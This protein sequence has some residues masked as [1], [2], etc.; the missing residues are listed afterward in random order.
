MS[1]FVKRFTRVG[2][3]PNLLGCYRACIRAG[4][5]KRFTGISDP[6]LPKLHKNLAI[7]PVTLHIFTKSDRRMLLGEVY[8]DAQLNEKSVDSIEQKLKSRFSKGFNVTVGVNASELHDLNTL[9]DKKIAHIKKLNNTEVSLKVDTSGIDRLNAKLKETFSLLTS[10]E[11]K[12]KS[13]GV[14]G[15]LASA[16]TSSSSNNS[17]ERLLSSLIAI[18][19]INSPKP[20]LESLLRVA[21]D[22]RDFQRAQATSNKTIAPSS[23]AR[24]QDGKVTED[25]LLSALQRRD[26]EQN[27]RAETQRFQQSVLE[28]F[29]DVKTGVFEGIGNVFGKSLGKGMKSA[30]ESLFKVDLQKT[31]KDF[32]NFAK[33][34]HQQGMIPNALA[35]KGTGSTQGLQSS[36]MASSFRSSVQVASTATSTASLL[37]QQQRDLQTTIR[38]STQIISGLGQS[39]GD[40]RVAKE[41]FDDIKNAFKKAY[42]SFQESLKKNNLELAKSYAD[43]L[44]Q[45]SAVAA[46]DIDRTKNELKRQ[47]VSG[48]FGSELATMA[49]S[50]KG[51]I[52]SRYVKPSQRDIGLAE[53]LD[54]AT[55]ANIGVAK[56]VL[57]GITKGLTEGKGA[58]Y[59]SSSQVAEIMLKAMRDKL[60]IKSPATAFIDMMRFV[61]Q[62]IVRGISNTKNAVANAASSLGSSV[63]DPFREKVSKAGHYISGSAFSQRR[64]FVTAAREQ[65]SEQFFDRQYARLFNAVSGAVAKGLGQPRSEAKGTTG[66]MVGALYA[67]S[68]LRN[69][70]TTT[71]STFLAPFLTTIAPTA[72]AIGQMKDSILT[73]LWNT[74]TKFIE[75]TQP[76]LVAIKTV[77]GGTDAGAQK[78]LNYLGDTSTKFGTPIQASGQAFVSLTAASEGTRLEGEGI[79]RL[80]EGISAS[81]RAMGLGLADNSLIFQA[82]TQ[83]LA[84]GKISMEELRQQ[85][86]EKFPPAMSV[87]A[88]ALGVTTG[89]L[90]QL[91]ASGV[92]LA[93]EVLPKVAD[94]LLKRYGQAASGVKNFTVA[95]NE[96]NNAAFTSQ[97]NIG[98]HFDGMFSGIAGI[99]TGLLETFNDNFKGI[100]KFLTVG[101]IGLAAQVAVGFETMFGLP[102]VKSKVTMFQNLMMSTFKN[103]MTVLTPFIFSILVD[104]AGDVLGAQNTVMENMVKG[105]TNMIVSVI[106]AFDNA[107][108]NFSGDSLFEINFDDKKPKGFFEG[109]LSSIGKIFGKIP[110]ITVE[111]AALYIMLESLFLLIKLGSPMTAN[112]INALKGVGASLLSAARNAK[113]W[114]GML[115]VI[116]ADSALASGAMVLLGIATKLALTTLVLAFA[117]SDFTNPLNDGISKAKKNIVGNIGEIKKALADL[118]GIADTTGKALQDSLSKTLPSKGLQLN[119]LKLLGDTRSFTSDD[120]SEKFNEKKGIFKFL[121]EVVTNSIVRAEA[122]KMAQK[123]KQRAD[124]VGVGEYFNADDRF[125]TLAK[126][127]LL[128]N[129]EDLAKLRTQLTKELAAIGQAVASPEVQKV[130]KELETYDEKL[131]ELSKERIR[132]AKLMGSN[133]DPATLSES[134]KMSRSRSDARIKE[135]DSEIAKVQ[136]ERATAA[137]KVSPLVSETRDIKASI[138]EIGKG[139][140]GSDYPTK[141]KKKFQDILS[142][143]LGVIK[144]T[145]DVLRDSN[146]TSLI[147]PLETSW[148]RVS[149]QLADA[150]DL[151]IRVQ[152]ASKIY[153]LQQQQRIL[154]GQGTEENKRKRVEELNIDVLQQ[155]E[156]QLLAVLEDRNRALNELLAIGSRDIND[157]RSKDTKK[158]QEDIDKD[159]VSLEEIRLQLA[160]QRQQVTERFKSVVKDIAKFY[161]DTINDTQKLAEDIKATNNTIELNAQKNKLKTALIGFQDTFVSSYVDGLIGMLDILNQPMQQY[162]QNVTQATAAKNQADEAIKQAREAFEKLRNSVPEGTI[163]PESVKRFTGNLNGTSQSSGVISPVSSKVS[164]EFG[165]RTIFGKRQHHNGI[166]Y[167]VGK[168]TSVRSPTSGAISRVFNDPAGGL[169]VTLQSVDSLGRKIEQS[170]LHLSQSMVKV[171]DYINQ[172]QEIAKSGNSGSRTTGAHLDWRIKIDGKYIN[173]RKFLQEALSI[174]GAGGSDDYATL[175]DSYVPLPNG[176]FAP[177]N[178]RRAHKARSQTS[179]SVKRFTSSSLPMG[180]YG[181]VQN[182]LSPEFIKG[183]A[184]VAQR[185]GTSPENLLAVMGFE[186][187]GSYSPSKVNPSSGATGLIQMMPQWSKQL[188]GHTTKQLAGMSQMEQ[189]KYAEK[190]L[191]ANIRGRDVS[192]LEDLYMSVLM[193]SYVGKSKNAA[194]P[195]WAYRQN[196]G[197]DIDKNGQISI[198]EATSKVRDYYNPNV[199]KRFTG[200]SQTARTNQGQMQEFTISGSPALNNPGLGRQPQSISEVELNA[201]V[202]NLERS[203]SLIRQNY[204]KVIEN[205]NKLLRSEEDRA[206]VELQLTN[207][208]N[209]RQLAAGVKENRQ[210]LQ[211]ERRQ[212]EDIQMNP[213]SDRW[214]DRHARDQI[215]VYRKYEDSELRLQD[216]LDKTIASLEQLTALRT[217][218]LGGGLGNQAL[219]DSQLPGIED[220][221]KSLTLQQNHYKALIK[222]QSDLRTLELDR[223]NATYAAEKEKQRVLDV[224]E[225]QTQRI[226]QA[227][228]QATLAEK[229]QR[230]QFDT[231]FG[232]PL[233]LRSE[234]QR[235]QSEL[236]L[237]VAIEQLG[238]FSKTS[239][240]GLRDWIDLKQGILKAAQVAETIRKTELDRALGERELEKSRFDLNN[241]ARDSQSISNIMSAQSEAYRIRGLGLT[242]RM[243]DKDRQ[244]MEQNLALQTEIQSIKEAAFQSGQTVEEVQHLINE[245]NELNEIKLDNIAAQFDPWQEVATSAVNGVQSSI[246]GLISG[247]MGLGDAFMNIGQQISQTLTKLAAEWVTNELLRGL[248]GF[249]GQAPAFGG[250]NGGGFLK[251]IGSLLGFRDGGD[252]PFIPAFAAMASEG[253]M[254]GQS[255]RREGNGAILATLTPGERVLTVEENRAYKQM[256][257]RIPNNIPSFKNGG[258]V[259]DVKR[260]TPKN[261]GG[262]T[263]QIQIDANVGSDIKSADER[264]LVKSIRAVTIAEIKRWNESKQGRR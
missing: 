126:Q 77:S 94:V 168:G 261:I 57:G 132:T 166:D 1:F 18:T 52:T 247:T 217:V 192:S 36:G 137:K 25:A 249:K 41:K 11:R 160:Q 62:G 120:L 12:A 136:N 138:E 208:R 135:I 256:L 134:E 127:Q 257:R 30:I 252:V 38:N 43:I 73:P 228:L 225:R 109:I 19:N 129:A 139:I 260:F 187:G 198:A 104:M 216:S 254:I 68:M 214:V 13:V 130:I 223:I 238:E 180:R 2:Y 90:G 16:S 63:I 170:F 118:K 15:E 59:Q 207:D 227:D 262:N 108:R 154:S 56:N 48:K 80:F 119:P 193:P 95:M 81:T 97:V 234:V 84:K 125:I 250:N 218:I 49:G 221:L 178:D 121:G 87:F 251:S 167:A 164:S 226:K 196:R 142:P 76:L 202:E 28:P 65:G 206:R 91:S 103:S 241:I 239:T 8:L 67:G 32:V 176:G 173:P 58:V 60:G 4:V 184:A 253:S 179:S 29:R 236:D 123:L 240:M 165:W 199:V 102:V 158:I 45:M 255:L 51:V 177:A 231:S 150:E 27:K 54:I 88:E 152:R 244:V 105:V 182:T 219:A 107:K 153:S 26:N 148:A 189:L 215:G 10:V 14:G 232:D 200:S 5:V 149:T 42:A 209:K 9:I 211:S 156:R 222:Q 213:N 117:N 64:T 162:L 204:G 246:E 114:Q 237:D 235:M 23:T 78:T 99:G 116:I 141:I 79:K 128:N 21:K 55:R 93:E 37:Q 224:R 245:L 181:A 22:I 230:T 188:T 53:N 46:S 147:T 163:A 100:S 20:A 50:T 71:A 210:A 122:Q 101:F 6:A 157:Q 258:E 74:V 172:G 143:V 146:L 34:S 131:K 264:E 82:Y 110:P 171:G 151:L 169:T 47:G 3:K 159:T 161:S 7:A 98:S 92:L 124:T 72:M 201:Q 190:Y 66:E 89:E 242:G 115:K 229:N 83:M 175:G 39:T 263:Y 220:A 212:V 111:F 61:G 248:F 113:S 24:P 191:K 205:A 112:V 185:I 35:G 243:I 259:G 31:G 96:F 174:Q 203:S 70:L 195:S 85:L 17:Q 86:S 145:E 186:T 155:T 69:P 197:L 133:V 233:A 183:V 194:L 44:K 144:G 106:S 75:A 33:Q 40:I 140:D